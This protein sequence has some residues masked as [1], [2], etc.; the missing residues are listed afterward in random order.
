MKDDL[1]KLPALADLHVIRYFNCKESN[2]IEG[3]E[4]E[5]TKEAEERLEWITKFRAWKVNELK[6]SHPDWKPPSVTIGR[7]IHA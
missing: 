6:S 2:V 4:V 1:L 7:F 5:K 3:F